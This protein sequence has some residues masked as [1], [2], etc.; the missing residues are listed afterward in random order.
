MTTCPVCRSVT[1]LR[2]LQR[3]TL[4]DSRFWFPNVHHTDHD[5]VVHFALGLAGEVGELVNLI[6]KINRGSAS[7]AEL[8]TEISH[9]M[10][11]CL[12][13]LCDMA[14]QLG[15]DLSTAV[16]AKR[17]VL[18]ERWGEPGVTP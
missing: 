11:D 13:Y 4:A 5:A 3:S 9:E 8:E 12:I 6:K 7:F 1:C 15:I 2:H 10:A 16:R 14:E 17:K 18:V